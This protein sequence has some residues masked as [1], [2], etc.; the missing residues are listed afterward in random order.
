MLGIIQPN[1]A[2]NW[3]LFLGQRGQ[4]RLYVND[5]VCKP[6]FSCRI[7][8]IIS[9]EDAGLDS[10]C[11]SDE[12]N[13]NV[14]SDKGFAAEDPAVCTLKADETFPRKVHDDSLVVH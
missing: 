5:L 2:Q 7:V 12:S 3:N 4:D 1:T 6:R 11:R 10:I 13:V 9:R 14:G 8:D